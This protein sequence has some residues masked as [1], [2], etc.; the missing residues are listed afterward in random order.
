MP[1]SAAAGVRMAF[2]AG[3]GQTAVPVRS[4]L[5][6]SVVALATVVAAV[7]FAANLRHLVSTPRLYGWSWDV[8]VDGQFGSFPGGQARALLTPI[9]GVASVAGGDYGNV[10][11]GGRAVAALGI[12]RLQ[13]EVFPTVVEGRPPSGPDEIVLGTNTLQLAHR[14]VGQTVAVGGAAGVRPMR[15]VGRAVFPA[16]GRGGFP[17][18][19]LGQGAAM[20]A[21]ALAPPDLPPDSYNFFLVRF[22]AGAD[23]AAVSARVRA[24][25]QAA[26][27]PPGQDCGVFENR[28]P[29]EIGGY[30]RV[31]WTPL[32]LAGLLAVLATCTMGHALVSS[33]RRRRRDLAVLKTLGFVRRQVSASVAWQ[34]TSLA[35]TALLFGVPLGLVAGRW[36]WTLFARQLGIGRGTVVPV[37]AVLVT[38]PAVLAVA[39]LV[40]ALPARAAARTRPALVL[41]TE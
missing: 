37:A 24:A 20:T 7:S 22:T 8:L 4:A 31:Q 25:A 12:D 26:G 5:I 19:S 18:T 9:P 14:S 6:G 33:I 30:A 36:G 38:I 10:T 16:L 2:E 3:R 41:R 27:C 23:R 21:S 40:A 39:N 1:P 29:G 11:I 15:I 28:R 34:A 35:V 32:V 17:P 13:G